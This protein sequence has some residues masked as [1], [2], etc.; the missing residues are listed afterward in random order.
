MVAMTQLMSEQGGQRSL[1][2]CRHPSHLWER[3]R[4]RRGMRDRDL[5]VAVNPWVDGGG[6][7]CGE[8]PH[9][10]RE[11]SQGLAHH[12]AGPLSHSRRPWLWVK[13]AG[14]SVREERSPYQT[15]SF[16]WAPCKREGR[17]SAEGWGSWVGCYPNDKPTQESTAALAPMRPLTSLNQL[18]SPWVT[19]GI[20]RLANSP[21]LL[22][23]LSNL[24]LLSFPG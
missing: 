7:P 6:T 9:P 2:S 15:S 24:M 8:A 23:P 20:T 4:R 10:I 17:E 3:H 1:E 14:G 13:G 5:D 16:Q 11:Y 21:F 18:T 19:W 12:G 22:P